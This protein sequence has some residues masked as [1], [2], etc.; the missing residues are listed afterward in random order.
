MISDFDNIK[1][2]L[3]NKPKKLELKIKKKKG[4]INTFVLSSEE[5]YQQLGE[6][7]YQAKNLKATEELP[8]PYWNIYH[9]IS[10]FKMFSDKIQY[11]E[12]F[13]WAKKSSKKLIPEEKKDDNLL[14]YSSNSGI[15]KYYSNDFFVQYSNKHKK[16]NSLFIFGML[17]MSS[18][19]EYIIYREKNSVHSY[20]DNYYA[21]ELPYYVSEEK[22]ITNDVLRENFKRIF[23]KVNY[24]I[25]QENICN[26]ENNKLVIEDKLD[27]VCID[28]NYYLWKVKKINSYINSQAIFNLIIYVFRFLEKGAVIKLSINELDNQLIIDIIE[29]INFYFEEV[30]IYKNA[31]NNNILS[32][33]FLICNNFKGITEKQLKVLFNISKEWNK[34]F[35]KCSTDIRDIQEDKYYIQSLINYKENY[36][37]ITEFN[38]IENFKKLKYFT[39]I[40]S[41]YN[42]IILCGNRIIEEQY[43]EKLLNTIKYLEDNNIE[44]TSKYSKLKKN[45]LE[46][47]LLINFNNM[48][49]DNLLKGDE[50]EIK[51][52]EE[53]GLYQL[54]ELYQLEN[55]LKFSKRILDT[56]EWQKYN[57]VKNKTKRLQLLKPYISNKISDFMRNYKGEV[58]QAFLKFYEILSQY[59]LIENKSTFQSFH[60]C[61]LP[62]QFILA[63]KYYIKTKTKIE[64]HIWRAQSLN[65][66]YSKDKQ[67]FGDNYKLIQK[68]PSNW[69]FGSD[70]SGD[71]TKTENIKYYK[72]I[73]S[74][75]DLASSDCGLDMREPTKAVYQDKN[76]SYINFCQKLMILNGLKKGS[77]Y[78]GKVF[79]PQTVSYIVAINYVI[80]KSFQE[81]YFHK[82]AINSGSGEV[83]II[84]KNFKG[85]EEKI[86]TKLFRIKDNLDISKIYIK[87]PRDFLDNYSKVLAIFIQRIINHIQTN[88]NNYENDE[89]F[90]EEKKINMI[91]KKNLNNWLKFYNFK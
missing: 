61:E 48:N 49:K 8:N 15:L 68:H 69:D 53:K 33:K 30:Y 24:N 1:I 9:L 19:E 42:N 82:T 56:F 65:P 25:N 46:N 13:E 12:D 21:L 31:L 23:S 83:Y 39:K 35:D 84:C 18:I 54:E 28:I 63:T 60:F 5:L 45:I 72:K 88:I 36:K 81:V 57:K 7:Y 58:S 16:E 64:K 27:L 55:N 34:L 66:F 87:I 41:V 89:A 38:D 70:G 47:Y 85:I 76:L 26:Q 67:I 50:N 32:Y 43:Q 91:Q 11:N 10:P 75:T 73:L 79:L 20:K 37:K 44:I 71:I 22:K 17:H 4:K 14:K 62:G 86:L 40:V 6:A 78:V 77:N 52:E 51:F 59:N 80:T 3:I 29:I 90:T 2:K 74:Q